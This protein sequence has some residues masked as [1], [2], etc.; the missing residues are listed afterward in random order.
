MWAS[1][2][3]YST[4]YVPYALV[5]WRVF[6]GANVITENK[7]FIGQLIGGVHIGSSDDSNASTHWVVVL[8]QANGG[9]LYTHAVGG[10]ISGQGIKKPF[11]RIEGERLKSTYTLTHVG[12]VT[13]KNT[14]QKMVEVVELEP[15]KSGNSC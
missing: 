4:S 1:F 3:H 5:L 15:M 12:Y 6:V 14:Q 2:G 9:Y 10:V 11:V 8:E 7:L 13:R